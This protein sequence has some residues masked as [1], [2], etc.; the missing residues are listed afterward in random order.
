L[1]ER[2]RMKTYLSK[3]VVLVFLLSLT[4]TVA[5]A[6]YI[7]TTFD[8]DL[9]EWRSNTP[10]EISWSSEGGNPGGYLK[11]TD[12]SGN[13]SDI[14]VPL[15]YLG[16]WSEYEGEII[17]FDHKVF[18]Q[19]HNIVDYFN[20]RIEMSGPAGVAVWEGAE[21]TG[22]TDWITVRLELS[23][24]SWSVIEGDWNRILTDV[25]DCKIGVEMFNNAY[26]LKEVCGIDNVVLVPEPC[27]VLLLGLGGLFIF[28]RR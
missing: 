13:E 26:G 15:S 22:V 20:Y 1:E 8:T 18:E 16:D 17:G 7:R 12:G 3:M 28:K 19:G 2:I 6:G 24:S 25:T 4:H 9:E 14:L 5:I 11:F 27:S 23:E 21:V 10:N